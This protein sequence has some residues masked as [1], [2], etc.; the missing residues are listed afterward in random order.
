MNRILHIEDH[1][2]DFSRFTIDEYGEIIETM[3][4]QGWVWTGKFIHAD[5][6]KVGTRPFIG[7][8]AKDK[9]AYLK[10]P[11]TKIEEIEDEEAAPAP[12]V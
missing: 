11:I 1:G 9:G 2:Q 10:Y 5:T 12:A 7:N 8:S 3:P 4:F 6:I